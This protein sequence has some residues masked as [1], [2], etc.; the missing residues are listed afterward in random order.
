MSPRLLTLWLAALL[1]WSIAVLTGALIGVGVVTGVTEAFALV[2]T[3]S[4]ALLI[5]AAKV[6]FA[7]STPDDSVPLPLLR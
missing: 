7:L 1:Y 6:Y 4:I 2:L 3:T 5:T